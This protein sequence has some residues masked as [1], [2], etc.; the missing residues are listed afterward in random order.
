MNKTILLKHFQT[1][2]FSVVLI[3]SLFLLVACEKEQEVDKLR[4]IVST[5]I[6]GTDPDDNQSMAHL[7]MYSDMFA[8]EGLLS[9]PS[10]GSGSK[11]EIL[12]MIELYR[13][14]YARLLRHEP[15]LQH[16]DSL[17]ALVKQGAKGAV[18][19]KGYR[20]VPT[21]ASQWLV[22]CARRQSEKPLWLLVWGGLDDV[23]QALHDAPD[24]ADK[25]RVYWIG[26]PNKK[27]SVNSYCYIVSHFPN[28]WMI[29]NNASYR[30]F[31]GNQNKK[32]DYNFHYY[33][34]VIAGAGHLGEDFKHYYRG[35]LKMGDTPSLLYLMHGDPENPQGESWGG[36]F[37]PIAYSAHRV[38]HRL[39]TEN[40]TVPVY[41]VVELRLKGPKINQPEGT[42]CLTLTIDRQTWDGYYLGEGEYMLRYAPK[43]PARLP[44]SIQSSIK[45]LDGLQGVLVV[46]NQWPGEP[47]ADDWTLGG[48][49]YSDKQS[50][51]LFE[52][53]W[54][55]C[56]TTS[57]YRQDVLDDWTKRWNWLK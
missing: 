30:G 46:G 20:D 43:A 44:Y 14:D 21:E 7:L 36:S 33:D 15:D 2:L 50:P 34:K 41:G 52:G 3:T 40:D 9:S 25:L 26:G 39:T 31:I 10:Y 17:R 5:D 19:M 45:A 38:F 8:W 32:D 4:V 23:A 42:P 53:K 55:G 51:E 13:Q 47:S 22:Q 57:Q 48:Q 35:Q 24:I 37:E 18:G 6:G 1:I 12:R 49:W 28:L 56:K 16:P 11:E 27:W 29:E 54:Q